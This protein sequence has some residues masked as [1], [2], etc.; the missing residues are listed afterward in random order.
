[1]HPSTEAL[2]NHKVFNDM[3][4]FMLTRFKELSDT[5][6]DD[7]VQNVLKLKAIDKRKSIKDILDILDQAMEDTNE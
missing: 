6:D 3:V 7:S 2:F 1:M 5:I 4:V